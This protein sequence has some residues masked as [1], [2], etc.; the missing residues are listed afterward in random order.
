MSRA[1]SLSGTKS[2]LIASNSVRTGLSWCA[3]IEQILICLV[4]TRMQA[5]DSQN[6]PLVVH[7]AGVSRV[8]GAARSRI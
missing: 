8:M 1:A 2:F 5:H 6:G 4:A 7:N 3:P